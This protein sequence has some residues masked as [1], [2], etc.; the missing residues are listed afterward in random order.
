MNRAAFAAALA[1]FPLA[2][3]GAIKADHASE[4]RPPRPELPPPPI[5]RSG[6]VW[7]AGG[8][9]AAIIFAVLC[10]PRRKPP[11]PPPDPFPIAQEKLTALRASA[12]SATPLAVSGIVR[13]YAAQ[14][15]AIEGSGLTSEELV[16]GLVT[17]RSCPVELTNAV[18]HFLADCDRAKFSPLPEHAE[19]SALL[20]ATAKLIEELEAARAKAAR[21]L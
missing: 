7:I 20:G 4:L 3:F 15:F 18:W 1:L 11:V 14:A 9:G 13:R 17:R 12:S 2:T 21:T 19:G 10:W 16:S 8:L 5:A 6:I